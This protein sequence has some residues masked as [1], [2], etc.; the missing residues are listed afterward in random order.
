MEGFETADGLLYIF[1][2]AKR[3]RR[4]GYGFKRGCLE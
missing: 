4:A 1:F 2:R 3:A